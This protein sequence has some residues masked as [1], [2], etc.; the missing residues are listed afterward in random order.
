[1]DRIFNRGAE[2]V[3]T[4]GKVLPK[5]PWQAEHYDIWGDSENVGIYVS[6]DQDIITVFVKQSPKLLD[7]PSSNATKL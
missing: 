1:M 3:L 5:D 4:S 2:P 7:F 6:N